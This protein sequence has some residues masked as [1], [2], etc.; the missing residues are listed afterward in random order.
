MDVAKQFLEAGRMAKAMDRLPG[1]PVEGP[2]P[3]LGPL[4]PLAMGLLMLFLP[5]VAV[6]LVWSSRSFSRAAQIALTVYGSLVTLVLAAA[7]LV[8]LR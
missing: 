6:T 2:L 3:E 4:S 1:G 7:A 8:S 5:P